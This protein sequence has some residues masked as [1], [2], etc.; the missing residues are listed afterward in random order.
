[1]KGERY[2]IE[3]SDG[4]VLIHGYISIREAFDFLSF[5]D[6]QGYDCLIP[7]DENSVLRLTKKQANHDATT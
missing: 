7:G 2:S 5:F 3:V 1:M 6:Q 4:E